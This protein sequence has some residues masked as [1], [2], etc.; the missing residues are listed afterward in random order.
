MLNQRNSGRAYVFD[1]IPILSLDL[2]GTQFSVQSPSESLFRFASVF[3][4]INYEYKDRYL[5]EGSVRQDGS[6]RFGPGNRNGT[7]GGG[8]LGWIMSEEK[9]F[10]DRIRFINFLK[11]RASYG[12]IGN[13]ELPGDF[14]YISLATSTDSESSYG[15]NSGLAFNTI[16]NARLRWES[17][18]ESNLALDA[19]FL[20]GR[21]R[22]SFDFYNKQSNNLLLGSSL[23]NSTG[24]LNGNYTFNV[25]SLRN[26]GVEV[27]VNTRNIVKGAFTWTSNFNISR[28]KATVLKLQPVAAG[29]TKI[30]VV[31]GGNNRLVEGGAFGAYFLPVYAGVD[32]KT[33]NELIY[34]VDQPYLSQ[35]GIARLTGNVID[36]TLGTNLNNHRMLITDKTPLPRFYGGLSNSFTYKGLELTVLFYFQYGN[37]LLDEGERNQSYPS[38]QQSLRANLKDALTD[39]TIPLVYGSPMAGINTTRFLHDCSFIRLRN[40]QL[41]YSIPSKFSRKY[42]IKNMRLFVAGQNLLTFTKFPG[43]DP[44]VFTTG[45]SDQQ[46][47]I[48]P[49]TTS[50][51]LPQV[52]TLMGGI[53]IN[54]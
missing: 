49:G 46:A 16:G 33:G 39:N 24:Y 11:L 1:G 38:E 31:D 44:E 34:E 36:A 23:A 52:K 18:T 9:F 35:T 4:R 51:N 40:L 22:T 2:A 42:G 5:L 19:E 20:K 13:A 50:Y 3:S 17:T 8:S 15:G 25:G 53:N 26:R 12:T 43:W 45:G 14:A 27:E 30:N 29:A 7:F 28:N 6:S 47:N 41:G 54:F 10:R 32:T 21:I 37:F 48:G